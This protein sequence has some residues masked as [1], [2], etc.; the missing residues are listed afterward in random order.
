MAYRRGGSGR[1]AEPVNKVPLAS[2]PQCNPC[3]EI[4]AAYALVLSGLRALLGDVAAD[5]KVLGQ[6]Q[7][8]GGSALLHSHTQTPAVKPTGALKL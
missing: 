8:L 3:S 5:V 4:A 2:R 7:R 1:A 6:A